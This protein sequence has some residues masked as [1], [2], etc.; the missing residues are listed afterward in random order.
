M[1]VSESEGAKFWLSV[2]TDLKNRGVEDILI[3]CID[4]LKGFPE[5]IAT[6]FPLTQIQTCVVHQIRNSL[7]YIAEKDK[8]EFVADLKLVYQAVNKEQGF[9]NLVV[10][11]EKWSKKYPVRLSVGK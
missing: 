11:D 10:L 8:K 4:G 3:A 5:A 2:I 6:V 1:Y 7:R 9:E